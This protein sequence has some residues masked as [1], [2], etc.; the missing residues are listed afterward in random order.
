[1]A[2]GTNLPTWPAIVFTYFEPV[3]LLIGFYAAFFDSSSFVSRQLPP[4]PILT[5]STVPPHA[6]I[7]SLSIANMF[8][9]QCMLSILFTIV[10]REPRL[11]RYYLA[12]AAV[13]DLGH[14]YA[15]YKVMGSD[16][17][18][19][20]GGYNDMMVGNVI[21]SAFLWVNR[22]LTLLGMFGKAGR[23]L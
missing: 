6:Q 1:M 2:L 18:W 12:A 11:T 19:D 13:G 14:I 5:S 23:R 9:V 7:L 20:F 15:S 8:L 17:F 10:T 16:M 3:S 4:T 22:T 21:V